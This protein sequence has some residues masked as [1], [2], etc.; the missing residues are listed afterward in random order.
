MK[1][2]KLKI[3]T[4]NSTLTKA[5]ES[6]QSTE[7]EMLWEFSVPSPHEMHRK[8]GMR[9]PKG[10]LTVPSPEQLMAPKKKRKKKAKKQEVEIT[11]DEAYAKA[12][13]TQKGFQKIFDK[14]KPKQKIA[15]YYKS[16]GVTHGQGVIYEPFIVGR[17]SYSKRY[18]TTKITLL[19][20]GQKKSAGKGLQPSLLKRK[21]GT[22]S[23]AQGD[24]AAILKGIYVP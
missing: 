8:H 16:F 9:L 5:I 20:P 21:D 3:E 18:A 23:M 6:L 13:K 15:I 22:V 14:L 10:T 2:E 12:E 24:M 7:I 1:L 19:L 4:I 11:Q 17:K